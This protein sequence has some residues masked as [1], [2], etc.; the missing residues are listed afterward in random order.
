M[1]PTPGGRLD[2][3][4]RSGRR[5]LGC[6]LQLDRRADARPIR[7][8]LHRRDTRSL[9]NQAPARRVLFGLAPFDVPDLDIPLVCACGDVRAFVTAGDVHH[10]GRPLRL[11]KR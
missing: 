7:R 8:Y 4:A 5:R 1:E 10:A 6:C 9:G 11:H 2:A 3:E